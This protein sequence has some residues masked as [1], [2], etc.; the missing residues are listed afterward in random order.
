[1]SENNK[2]NKDNSNVKGKDLHR[3]AK[4]KALSTYQ[5]SQSYLLNPYTDT[6]Y[7]IA[8]SKA[9]QKTFMLLKNQI[10]PLSSVQE[11]FRAIPSVSPYIGI[12]A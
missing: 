12:K 6:L 8:H 3:E 7:G 5:A 11:S 1:M 10:H 2:W 9:C 4:A